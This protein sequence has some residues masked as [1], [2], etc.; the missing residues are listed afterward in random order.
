M[1]CKKLKIV[2]N[3]DDNVHEIFKDAFGFPDFYGR[4][5]NALIDCLSD[6]RYPEYG[7]SNFV[8]D[9]LDQILLL[10]I[11][12]FSKTNNVNKTAILFAIECVNR[13]NIEVG[14]VPSIHLILR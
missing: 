11:E 2:I 4:N 5:L 3:K 13:H 9:S 12:N 10:E 7:M 1:N 8:L 14:Q 6:L